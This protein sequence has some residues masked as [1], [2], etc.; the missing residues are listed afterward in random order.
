MKRFLFVKHFLLLLCASFTCSFLA[1]AESPR[2]YYRFPAIHRDT[3]VF[4]AEGD[5]WKVGI[6]GGAARRLT[7]HPGEESNC[8]ISPDGTT[9]AFSAQYEGPSEVYTMPLDGGLPTRRTFEGEGAFVVGWTPDGKVLYT[10]RHFSTLPDAKL[11]AIDLKTGKSTLIP[12]SQAADGAFEP[13]G[14]TLFFTRLPFQGSSTKRYAGG[15]AQNLWKFTEGQPEATPL[16]G[17]YPGTSKSPMWWKGRIYFLSDRDGTMNI[18]SLKDDGGDLRQHTHHNGWDVKSPS[19]SEGRIAYQLG[20]DLHLFD[21]AGESDSVLPV[22]LASDLDQMREKWVQKPMEYL[23]SAHTSP[24]GDRVVL[25]ARGQ[26]FV[27]PAAQGRFVEATRKKRVR[28]RDAAFMPDGKS[29]LALADESA[30]VE[31]WKIPA[32][33]V[34]S[35]ESLTNDAKVLRFDGVPSPDGKRIAYSD[36]D[37]QLWIYDIDQKKQTRVAVSPED[38]FYDL[39]WSPDSQWLAYVE[40][41]SN[42]FPQIKLYHLPDGK[43]TALTSDRVESY[44]PAWS[45]DGKWIYFLSDRN[46]QSLVSAPWG[47]R[48]PEPFFDK[49]AKIYLMALRKDQRSPFQPPDELHPEPKEPPKKDSEPSKPGAPATEAAPPSTAAVTVDLDGIQTRIFEV[50]IPAGNY[51]DLS[52]NDKRLFWTSRD[53]SIERKRSLVT[54]DINNKE[55]TPKTLLEDIK[56]Y[57]LSRDGKKIL[58]YKGDDLYVFE[59]ASEAPAKIDNKKVNLRDWT[60]SLDPKEEWRQMFAEA[61]RLERDYFYDRNMHGVQWPEM[62]K[63]YSPLI[64]RVTT[65]AE[66][67]DLIAQMVGELSALH[68]FVVGGDQRK[69][70][71]EVY[72]ASLGAVLTRDENGG[73]YR[74][75]HIYQSEPDFPDRI[76]PLAKPGVDVKEGDVI[77]SIDGISLLSVADPAVLLRNRAAR[78]VLLHVKLAGSASGRDVIVIPVTQRQESNLRYDEWERTRRLRVEEMGKGEIG[79]LHLRAMGPNDI[80]QWAR[81]YYPVFNRAGLIIDVRHNGGGN[82]DSW[83]LE[84]LLRKAWFYWQPRVGNPLWNMQ[85]AFRGHLVVLCDEWTGSDGEAF[86]E[87]FRRLGLGKVIGK[88]TWGGEIWLSFSNWLVDKGIASAAEIGV[89]GPEGRWL[90]EG[91]GVDPDIT[92]D[93]LPHATFNGEDAQLQAAVKYLQEQMRSHPVATPPVPPYPNKSLKPK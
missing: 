24:D 78:Q 56:S 76:S 19:L 59:A 79:Y 69:G 26:V 80:A 32:N 74:V 62:L 40:V 92:V 5:L 27:A 44:R 45:P 89:Y 60:F 57:E 82:I 50:P 67:S 2:G 13:A 47:P 71:E 54:L 21:I 14:K 18:W 33:G 9:L 3:I 35:A 39:S 38:H 86:T 85:Y 83:I 8:A 20:A 66:L 61:W 37:Q 4:S 22:T 90:I 25:T 17:D 7:S 12:L 91:H 88:R 49:S 64:D 34:G 68:I 72:P 53:T 23:T 55:I 10:T 16:T 51:A 41:A 43:I 77:E 58:V 31:F 70:Q 84:K 52:I 29:I 65:R 42:T 73:G 1:L 46:F 87:G 30:E 11:S 36:K 93:N 81:D 15:T 48:Q 6:Q 28:Y 75:A 63:K